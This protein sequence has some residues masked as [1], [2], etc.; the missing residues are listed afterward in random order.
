MI[1]LLVSRQKRRTISINNN[2]AEE[3]S[4]LLNV[5]SYNFG[6]DEC[7]VMLIV[8]FIINNTSR[9]FSKVLELFRKKIFRT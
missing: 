2:L 5:C 8:V 9:L 7:A 1:T 4:S 6:N 3:C